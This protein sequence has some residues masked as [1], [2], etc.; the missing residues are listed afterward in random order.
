MAQR[1]YIH[2]DFMLHSDPARRLYHDFAAGLP[3]IDYHCHLPPQQVAQDHRFE[4][5]TEIWLYGDHYKWRLMRAAGVPERLCTGDASD[6]EK[7]QAW[8]Q[9]VPQTLRNPLYVWTHMELARPFG[10]TDRL[11]NPETAKGIYAQCNEVLARPDRSA[12]GIME[13]FDVRLVCT[14]DDPADSLEHHQ[15]IAADASFKIRVLPTFRPDK[16]MAADDPETYNAY[17]DRLAQAAGVEIRTFDTLIEALRKRHAFFHA[18]GCRLSD[19]GLDT[20]Y[21]ADYTHA[22]VQAA[23]AKVRSGQTLSPEELDRLKSA[24]LVEFGVMDAEAGWTQQFHFGAQRN[25]NTRRFEQLGPD[26]GIDSIGDA[27]IAAPLGRLL[28]RLERQDKLARTI[29][30]NLNP[31]DNALL[32][33]MAGNFQGHGVAGKMQFG[34]AWWFLDQEDGIRRQMQDLSN[35]GLLS[36]FL[37]MLTDSRSFLSYTRHDYFRRILCDLLGDDIE[38]GLIPADYDLVG[39]MVRDISYNNAA[40][41]FGFDLPTV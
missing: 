18:N 11:L 37:G 1:P 38:R 3:I 40:R 10:I 35:V 27:P 36:R 31:R 16:A 5:I 30:Y 32:A 24:M 22:Q 26:V 41:Y 28:D 20:A 33:T 39:A 4:T 29:L 8:A 13:Y 21:G 19:H 25:N 6:E 34:A 17:L 9:T 15:A 12:R 2:D 23:F 14:T 7:F